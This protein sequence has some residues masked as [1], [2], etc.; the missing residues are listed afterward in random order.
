[1]VQVSD[2]RLFIR[3]ERLF[4]KKTTKVPKQTSSECLTFRLTTF[5]LSLENRVPNK[6]NMCSIDS[7]VGNFVYEAPPRQDEIFNVKV[8]LEVRVHRS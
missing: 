7:I 5:P 8:N 2:A 1:M 3:R 6:E 4:E